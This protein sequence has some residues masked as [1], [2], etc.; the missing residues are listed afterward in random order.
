[1]YI[2]SGKRSL[3]KVDGTQ[4]VGENSARDVTENYGKNYSL[5]TC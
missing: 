1:V 5:Y 4:H 2:E 3:Y